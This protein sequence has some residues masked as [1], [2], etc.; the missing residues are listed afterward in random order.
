[1]W[2]V[3]P[4]LDKMPSR[5][6][7][8]HHTRSSPAAKAPAGVGLLLKAFQI[9]DLFSDQRPAWTQAEI[10]R[11]TG[12]PRSTLSRLERF[13]CSPNYR[14]EQRARY[15]LGLAAIDLGRR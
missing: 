2:A 9:L 8:T 14:L 13:L 5:P 4:H 15:P 3:D 1:M 12:L 10:A 11:M 6:V 7:N